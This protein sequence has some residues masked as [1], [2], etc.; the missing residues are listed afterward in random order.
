[1]SKTI[2]ELEVEL[3]SLAN[4]NKALENKLDKADKM[5]EEFKALNKRVSDYELQIKTSLEKENSYQKNQIFKNLN[6]DPKFSDM[7]SKLTKD[8]EISALENELKKDEYK[9]FKS[10]DDMLNVE[11]VDNEKLD[12]KEDEP[13]KEYVPLE[14]KLESYLKKFS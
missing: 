4:K 10:K 8:I 9:L 7:V 14:N 6:I 1:M 13:K 2:E 3:K 5:E 12:T 11:I